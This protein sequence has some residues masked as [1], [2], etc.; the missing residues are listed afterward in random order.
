MFFA[1]YWRRWTT[2]LKSGL[3]LE[4]DRI[5]FSLEYP[6]LIGKSID[7]PLQRPKSLMGQLMF[8]HIGKAVQSQHTLLLDS[9]MR[10]TVAVARGVHGSGRLSLPNAKNFYDYLKRKPGIM[11]IDNKD[12]S[13]CHALS[14]WDVLTLNILKKILHQ[15]ISVNVSQALKRHRRIDKAN[16]QESCVLMLDSK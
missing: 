5:G 13:A 4:N 14:W 1:N 3:D 16:W 10:M 8:M 6:D 7:V 11:Q 12:N 2:E 9:K 15:N